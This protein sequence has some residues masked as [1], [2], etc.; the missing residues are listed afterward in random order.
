MERA[1]RIRPRIVAMTLA[2]GLAATGLASCASDS[3]EL[4]YNYRPADADIYAG[5]YDDP[6]Y[7]YDGWP[8]FWSGI[9][10]RRFGYRG[11]HASHFAGHHFGAHHR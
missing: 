11:F 7:D 10:H 8:Y 3:A 6:Y 2:L 1:M 9:G 4:T 5:Y